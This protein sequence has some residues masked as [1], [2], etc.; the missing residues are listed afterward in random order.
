MAL[1]RHTS[2]ND[3]QK[4]EMSLLNVLDGNDSNSSELEGI[5]S[6]GGSI[7]LGDA[8]AS[9]VA[10]MMTQRGVAPIST[11]S[12]P[13]SP[14][15]PSL[16]SASAAVAVASVAATM[17][18]A[19]NADVD[20][21]ENDDDGKCADDDSKDADDDDDDDDDSD[22]EV[23]GCNCP[24]CSSPLFS[25]MMA[26]CGHSICP[27]CLARLGTAALTAQ[28]NNQLAHSSLGHMIMGAMPG[29]ATSSDVTVP[30]CPE[31]RCAVHK[32]QYLRNIAIEKAAQACYPDEYELYK[33]TKTTVVD[34]KS[35]KSELENLRLYKAAQEEQAIVKATAMIWKAIRECM[36]NSNAL[37]I[38]ASVPPRQRRNAAVYEPVPQLRIGPNGVIDASELVQEDAEK[39]VHAVTSVLWNCADEMKYR[40]K[41]EGLEMIT[42]KCNG[43]DHALITWP[44][45]PS[46]FPKRGQDGPNGRRV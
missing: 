24:I 36:T 37:L 35:S 12:A 4:P 34:S 30:R 9:R 17:A 41:L 25:A 11:R 18:S 33:K 13:A 43:V 31:C 46:Q 40:L 5:A 28:I 23:D 19:M 2:C 27:Q 42:F 8:L 14:A 7:P 1:A 22:A 38:P 3:K 10:A 16:S 26:P 6:I 39:E 15:A 20:D 21:D 45:I 32:S 44:T 29:A